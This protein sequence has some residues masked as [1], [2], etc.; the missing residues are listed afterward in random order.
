MLSAFRG[1]MP[2]DQRKA[3]SSRVLEKY[4]DR[5]PIICERAACH[6]TGSAMVPKLDKTK[7]L[8][9][10]DLT[11]GQFIYV[12]RKRLQL[13]PSQSLFIFIDGCIPPSSELLHS[14]YTRHKDGD[15]FLYVSYSGENTFGGGFI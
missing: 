3:E 12:I 1:S 14:I 4:P 10:Q 15:G 7:F 9:P 11:A 8:V 6:N 2:A 13:P 5:V